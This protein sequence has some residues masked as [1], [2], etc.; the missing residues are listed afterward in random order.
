MRW[1]PS[2]VESTV[3]VGELWPLMI[4]ALD[5]VT[6]QLYLKLFVPLYATSAV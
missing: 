6:F 3:S 5:G 4:R 1:L 2:P